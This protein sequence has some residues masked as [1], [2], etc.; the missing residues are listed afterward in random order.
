[1]KD[2]KKTKMQ[3]QK[4]KIKDVASEQYVDYCKQKVFGISILLFWE[5]IW[6]LNGCLILPY[7]AI[8]FISKSKWE[9]ILTVLFLI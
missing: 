8:A 5:Y 3:N 1:M 4:I 6:Y 9:N 7:L 2:W